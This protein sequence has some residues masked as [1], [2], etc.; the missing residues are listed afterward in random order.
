MTP[1]T[2]GPLGRRRGLLEAPP[3]RETSN[4]RESAPIGEKNGGVARHRRAAAMR[5]MPL[6]ICANRRNLRIKNVCY[7]SATDYVHIHEKR[8]WPWYFV[9][10]RDTFQGF[11]VV[12]ADGCRVLAA[13][14]IG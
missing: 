2:Q 3:A 9:C 12:V 6:I 14:S 7:Q 13:G 8:V 5:D 4:L 1:W 11:S 10:C